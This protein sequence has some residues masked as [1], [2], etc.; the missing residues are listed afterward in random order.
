MSANGSRV[1]G[2]KPAR[3]RIGELAVRCGLSRRTIDYYTQLGLLQPAARTTGNYRLYDADAPGRIAEIRA[4]QARRLS[5]SEIVARLNDACANADGDVVERF[6]QVACELD[7]LH[8]ELAEIWPRVRE[9][10]LEQAR[11]GALS[12]AARDTL[13]RTRGLAALLDSLVFETPSGQER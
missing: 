12:Q 9:A 6:R 10:R 11:H 5:L 13:V 8:G 1:G 7:R 4:L 3:Y 2:G